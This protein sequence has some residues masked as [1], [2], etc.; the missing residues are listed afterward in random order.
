MLLVLPHRGKKPRF[1]EGT[2]AGVASLPVPSTGR[3]SAHVRVVARAGEGH[4]LCV[5]RT[6]LC[7]TL[8]GLEDFVGML[9]RPA[10]SQ[11][12][13]GSGLADVGR[14]QGTPPTQQAFTAQVVVC[15]PQP[16][17]RYSCLREAV[18]LGDA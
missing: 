2:F 4:R 12:R 16:V 8:A 18:H 15:T 13:V 10:I 5:R 3:F 6:L 7:L 9:S 17:F 14:G 1:P 11:G